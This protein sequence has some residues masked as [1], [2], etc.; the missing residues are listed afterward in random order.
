MS[1]HLDQS[2]PFYK[3]I[4]KKECKKDTYNKNIHQ[5]R[6]YQKQ[7]PGNNIKTSINRRLFNLN[8]YGPPI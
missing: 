3:F 2:I 1:T 6:V 7:K 4:L 8:K 5:S